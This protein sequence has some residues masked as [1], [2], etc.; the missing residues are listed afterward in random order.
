MAL[1]ENIKRE[2]IK[3]EDSHS[4]VGS[5]LQKAVYVDD[6]CHSTENDVRKLAEDTEW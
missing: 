3:V 2:R 1:S 6:I 4:E 5:I